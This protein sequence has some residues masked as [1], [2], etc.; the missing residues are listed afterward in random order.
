MFGDLDYRGSIF[1]L[2]QLA[3]LIS[4]ED[5]SLVK[6]CSDSDGRQ[7]GVVSK[8]RLRCYGCVT[9][10]GVKEILLMA[11]L[12]ALSDNSIHLKS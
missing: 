5:N 4:K 1:Y 2:F 12:G 9:T 10:E 7:D 8:D 11:V 3:Q 6:M